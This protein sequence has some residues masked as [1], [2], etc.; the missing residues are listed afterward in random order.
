[1]SSIISISRPRMSN[2][3]K[4]VTADITV[5]GTIREYVIAGRASR[6]SP[7]CSGLVNGHLNLPTFGQTFS[8]PPLSFSDVSNL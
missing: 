8:P 3:G 2:D 6:R 5:E 1:V 7:S 4:T